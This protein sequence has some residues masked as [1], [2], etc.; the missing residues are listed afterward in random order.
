MIAVSLEQIYYQVFITYIMY[1]L[2][3]WVM[4]VAIN[5]AMNK[6]RVFYQYEYNVQT[7]L[8]Y[9][10]DNGICKSLIT[11]VKSYTDHVWKRQKGTVLKLSRKYSYRQHLTAIYMIF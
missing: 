10:K 7:M 4:A 3:M 8:H 5:F 9:W 11:L 2:D 1:L 6:Y